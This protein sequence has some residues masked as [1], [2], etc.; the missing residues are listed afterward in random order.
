[1]GQNYPLF[2]CVLCLDDLRLS[3]LMRKKLL[4]KNISY[5]R[6]VKEH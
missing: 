6:T 5:I 1:M 2:Y 3:L 4:N